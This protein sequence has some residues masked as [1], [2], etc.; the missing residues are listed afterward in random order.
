MTPFNRPARLPPGP[1]P[2]GQLR[3]NTRQKKRR[4]YFALVLIATSLLYLALHTRTTELSDP[5]IAAARSAKIA[6]AHWMGSRMGDRQGGPSLTSHHEKHKA[7][8]AYNY[9]YERPHNEPIVVWL[10]LFL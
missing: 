6:T 1:V 4:F 9:R 10:G 7:H 3:P 8:H 2:F 5:W